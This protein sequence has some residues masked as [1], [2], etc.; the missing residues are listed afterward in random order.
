MTPQ[1]AT[2]AIRA[3]R[4]R[5][6][7]VEGYT[8]EHDDLQDNGQMLRAAVIYYQHA[9]RPDI[10]LTMEA[11]GRPLGW[12]WDAEWW[13][14]K[15]RERDLVRAG[16]LCMAERD[17]LRRQ[18]LS[19]LVGVGRGD[20]RCAD[21]VQKDDWWPSHVRHKYDLIVSALAG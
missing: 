15:D 18:K 1:E 11:D 19:A 12:P 9:A 14:P 16:A 2:S 7:A 10:P 8:P 3:E 5:Q 21:K 20:G 17:R 4:K 6:V 13:K